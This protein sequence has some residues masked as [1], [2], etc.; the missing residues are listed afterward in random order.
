MT[1]LRIYGC[2]VVWFTLSNFAGHAMEIVGGVGAAG[3]IFDKALQ[4]TLGRPFRWWD[5]NPT[6]RILNRFSEDVEVMD[7]SLTNILGV[8]F[9]A[10]IYFVGHV[11]V[12]SISNP[13]SL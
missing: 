9:G 4:T 13:M 12:L 2:F 11:F 7:A 1:L 3:C 10:T 8:I 6:G 5:T